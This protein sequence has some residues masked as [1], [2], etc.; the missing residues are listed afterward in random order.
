MFG[1]ALEKFVH[2]RLQGKPCAVRFCHYLM[3]QHNL[4][5][6]EII[7]QH[8]AGHVDDAAAVDAVRR[9]VRVV[10]S[11][12]RVSETPDS[13]ARGLPS[14]PARGRASRS[15]TS[16]AARASIRVWGKTSAMSELTLRS[17]WRKQH[18]QR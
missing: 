2:D 5:A 7:L 8:H 14:P 4:L 9:G 18:Q 13:Q 6:L 1:N 15:A 10:L 17:L 12:A 11:L 16:I 3:R